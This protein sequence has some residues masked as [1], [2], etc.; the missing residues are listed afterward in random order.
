LQERGNELGLVHGPQA[1][2]SVPEHRIEEAVQPARRALVVALAHGARL[3]ASRAARAH[4]AHDSGVHA[5][6]IHRAPRLCDEPLTA[7][8]DALG[9]ALAISLG[10]EPCAWSFISQPPF[11][12]QATF[13]IHQLQLPTHAHH[14]SANPSAPRPRSSDEGPGGACTLDLRGQKRALITRR[15]GQNRFVYMLATHCQL[16]DAGAGVRVS[17]STSVYTQHARC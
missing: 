7:A 6:G 12:S 15:V 17:N 5:R 11:I 2:A 4:C 8:G 14:S 10:A 1:A 9:R 3:P 16:C 13:P